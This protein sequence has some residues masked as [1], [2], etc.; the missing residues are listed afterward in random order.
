MKKTINI[1]LL[2]LTIAI[3]TAIGYRAGSQYWAEKSFYRG[4]YLS[5]YVM[6]K[7]ID[8]CREAT[9]LAIHNDWYSSPDPE[10]L[11]LDTWRP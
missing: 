2:A 4:L 8:G 3:C 11:G 7:T 5:C 1:I 9:S 6:F 10:Q